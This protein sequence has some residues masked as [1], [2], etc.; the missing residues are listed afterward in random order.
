MQIKK[1]KSGSCRKYAPKMQDENAPLEVARTRHRKERT[2]KDLTAKIPP[3]KDN[4]HIIP[5]QNEKEKPLGVAGAKRGMKQA[6]QL[7][8]K[9][10][11]AI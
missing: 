10:T 11:E 7:P 4:R 6:M 2:K 8:F 1:Q 5:G 9:W 3:N